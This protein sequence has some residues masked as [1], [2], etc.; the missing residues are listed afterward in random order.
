MTS[1]IVS[2]FIEHIF[3][4][5]VSVHTNKYTPCM[6]TKYVHLLKTMSATHPTT[7]NGATSTDIL[8]AFKKKNSIN[9]P[10]GI[11]KNLE[12]FQILGIYDF[13]GM[14]EWCSISGFKICLPYICQYRSVKSSSILLHS[15][16]TQ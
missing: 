11:E 7:C 15:D 14:I 10:N 12:V 16:S 1:E 3:N 13:A 8:Q 4:R 2:Q 9:T 5:N 6:V